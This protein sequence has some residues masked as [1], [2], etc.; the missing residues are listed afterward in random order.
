MARRVAVVVIHQQNE[1]ATL[2]REDGARRNRVE[3]RLPIVAK[4]KRLGWAS[5]DALVGRHG[6]PDLARVG[7]H[8]ANES[9]IGQV[10]RVVLHARHEPF[11]RPHR[12]QIT[13]AGWLHVEMLVEPKELRVVME[14]KG[15]VN[16][17]REHASQTARVRQPFA[18][19]GPF[20]TP[21]RDG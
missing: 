9:P 20:D 11:C 18:S 8:H 4:T 6:V 5:G 14:T 21:N 13:V 19:N 7:P 12:Q 17:P 16:T 2:Q 15:R 10:H 3:Q 1:I